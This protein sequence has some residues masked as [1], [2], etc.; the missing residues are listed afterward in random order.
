MTRVYNLHK[1]LWEIRRSAVLK[2]RYLAD[3]DAV[4]D[5]FGVDGELRTFMKQ[6]DFKSMYEAGANPYLLYFCAIQLEVDRADY[7]AQI[8][9]EKL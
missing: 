8:R 1:L 2:D 4:L 3:P 9:G 5:E 6:L 7:Y